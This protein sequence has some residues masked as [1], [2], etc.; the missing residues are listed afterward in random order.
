MSAFCKKAWKLKSLPPLW[1]WKPTWLR[2][3]VVVTVR[4]IEVVFCVLLL[5]LLKALMAPFESDAPRNTWKAHKAEW[6]GQ[7]PAG[8][9]G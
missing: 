4:P 6:N 9:D 3:L 7:R 2:R 1:M 8:Y 5:M